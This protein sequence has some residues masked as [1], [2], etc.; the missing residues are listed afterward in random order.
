MR[1]EG[2]TTLEWAHEEFGHTDLGDTRRTARL[3]RMAAALA[4]QQGG[5]VLTVFR[6]NA[7]Q[8]GAYDLLGN[9]RVR[10]DPRL[11]RRLRI[12]GRAPGQSRSTVP[13][14]RHAMVYVILLFREGFLGP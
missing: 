10:S 1:D 9:E 13:A 12:G 2:R 14:F 5:K 6:S 7:E 11:P 8:Q 4:E 3:V